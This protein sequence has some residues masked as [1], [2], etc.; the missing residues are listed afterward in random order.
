MRA[1]FLVAAVVLVLAS[2]AQ[3]AK[4]VETALEVASHCKQVAEGRIEEAR[5]GDQLVYF[6][7]NFET[8]KCWGFFQAVQQAVRI[9]D[10]STQTSF[11]GV[12]APSESTL[13]QIVLIFRRYV[14]VNP[15]VGH[16]N[17]FYV[18]LRALD[19]AFPCKD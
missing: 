12:C 13:I 7:S 5:D 17:A 6:E 19:A 8:G 2:C 11:L 4:A 15:S 3:A 18:A 10:E 9:G 14:E 16:E 1:V